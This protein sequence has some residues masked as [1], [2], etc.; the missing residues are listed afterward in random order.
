MA[1]IS[2]DVTRFLSLTERE[3]NKAREDIEN[4]R[5]KCIEDGARLEL[6][7][8]E[9]EEHVDFPKEGEGSTKEQTILD[10]YRDHNAA[11]KDHIQNT[12]LYLCKEVESLQE[13]LSSANTIFVRTRK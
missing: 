4:R 3:L 9:T 6:K 1:D 5:E 7:I 8:R 10:A 2:R 13:K 11:L 12:H